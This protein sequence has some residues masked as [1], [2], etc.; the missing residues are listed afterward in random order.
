MSVLALMKLC[1]LVAAYGLVS[2][3]VWIFI[4]DGIAARIVYSPK[5]T[6]IRYQ[7][8]RDAAF[9]YFTGTQSSGVDHS[10][11]MRDLWGRYA[12]DIV[13]QYNPKRF[14]APT[15]VKT[16]YDQLRAWGYR[17]VILDGA[18]LGFMLVTDLI[19]YDRLHGNQFKFAVIEQDGV[20]STN[21]LVQ[22]AQA[23]A[24]A[25]IW[26]AGPVANFLFTRL[27]WKAGFNPPP[28]NK[29][30]AGVDDGLLAQHYQ[31]S[32]T[33]PLSGWTGELRY[34][35]G[36][37]AYR[38]GQY[39]GIPI[40]IMRSHPEGRDGDDGVVKSTAANEIQRIFRGGTI[41][42]VNGSTHIGFA[43]YPDLWRNKFRL[44]FGALTGW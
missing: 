35:A 32:K 3:L 7:S 8:D 21:D 13:V 27:F 42:E 24:V 29:L 1:G 14:D 15:I 33:Y 20:T 25:R 17:K 11:Q 30:G 31:A 39:A 40:V 44:A 38:A 34:M 19:D 2:L 5:P 12:D 22:G 4:F 6:I 18:S 37:A 41:I 23:R 43:E 28:R 10:A 36:H 26:H 16:T 9:V